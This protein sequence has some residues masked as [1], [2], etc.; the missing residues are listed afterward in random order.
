VTITTVKYQPASPRLEQQFPDKKPL[1]TA[2]QALAEST[3]CLYCY[4]APCINACPTRIKIP[5][6]IRKIATGNVRGAARTILDANMLGLS[7][8]RVCPVEVLCE[9]DCVYNAMGQKP[10]EI[11][12]LQ[13]YATE[14]AYQR[15]I[16]YFSA[17]APTGKRVVLVGA[18][19]ASL[20]CA[21]DLVRMGHAAVVLEARPYPGGLNTDGV[22][23]RC[24]GR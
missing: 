14:Y 19:P 17:G 1:M 10:I 5:E 3:R 11:G 22:A 9:G 4:D 8:A 21:H 24:C 2:T 7:C 15:Q 16:R 12:R 20:A 18:G 23:P 6:F 13:R